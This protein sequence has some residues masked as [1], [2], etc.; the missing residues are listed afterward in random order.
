MEVVVFCADLG[1]AKYNALVLYFHSEKSVSLTFYSRR[2][3][4]LS[5]PQGPEPGS[6]GG[7][8]L[9]RGLALRRTKTDEDLEVRELRSGSF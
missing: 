3:R 6:S 4:P 7:G 2:D 8:L 1:S 5:P 9:R